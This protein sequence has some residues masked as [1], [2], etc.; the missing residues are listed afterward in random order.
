MYRRCPPL[1]L[2]GT[3]MPSNSFSQKRTVDFGILS[4]RLRCWIL[5]SCSC[6]S[7]DI[8][9]NNAIGAPKR[10]EDHYVR[11]PLRLRQKAKPFAPC[12]LL[13]TSILKVNGRSHCPLLG[14]L[15]PLE[16]HGISFNNTMNFLTFFLISPFTA[17][18][19][20]T[21]VKGQDREMGKLPDWQNFLKL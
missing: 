9:Y 7:I 1:V 2:R 12:A 19:S 13:Y 21:H 20:L 18:I 8:A 16:L 6:R 4:F 15:R 5:N 10:L 11:G 17:T 3:R 14:R